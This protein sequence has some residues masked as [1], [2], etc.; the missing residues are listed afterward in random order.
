MV[1]ACRFVWRLPAGDSGSN[2]GAQRREGG[3]GQC[4]I[5]PARYGTGQVWTTK[6]AHQSGPDR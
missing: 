1:Q 5:G 2:F 6:K 4:V 3:T